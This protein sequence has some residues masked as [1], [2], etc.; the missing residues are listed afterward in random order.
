[1]L[2][3]AGRL[4]DGDPRVGPEGPPDCG[5]E[6]RVLADRV[7]EHL[8]LRRTLGPDQ[9]HRQ[10]LALLDGPPPH[11]GTLR[12]GRHHLSLHPL[13]PALA[14]RPLCGGQRELQQL[15]LRRHGQSLGGRVPQGQQGHCI[16]RG[17][18]TR[19]NVEHPHEETL[20]HGQVLH[21]ECGH[22]HPLVDLRH[23]PPDVVADHR[24]EHLVQRKRV[25]QHRHPDRRRL[26]G[27]RLEF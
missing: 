8:E 25:N 9:L 12:L 1:V 4:A 13:L 26:S 24:R 17:V 2:V 14:A 18:G 21:E 27:G 20:R 7:A 6:H 3:A 10:E 19:D 5:T 23:R 11:V 16:Q 22:Q 15:R